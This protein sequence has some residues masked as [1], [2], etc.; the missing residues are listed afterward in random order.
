MAAWLFGNRSTRLSDGNT[1]RKAE[2]STDLGFGQIVFDS[3]HAEELA[4]FWSSLVDRQVLEGANQFFADIP[5]SADRS[6]PAM[7]FIAVPDPRQGKNRLHVDLTS[8]DLT[9]AVDRAVSLGA[10]KVADFD[11]YGTKWTTLADPEG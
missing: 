4:Q 11:E 3:V 10:R 9:A 1:E 2:M 6:F 5:A 7:M 8:G